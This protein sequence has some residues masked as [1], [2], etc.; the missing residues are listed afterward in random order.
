[1]TTTR[2]EF[3]QHIICMARRFASELNQD[4]FETYT[5][6]IM[7]ITKLSIAKTLRN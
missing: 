4:N 5:G 7:F 6:I 1:M 2:Q 3:I